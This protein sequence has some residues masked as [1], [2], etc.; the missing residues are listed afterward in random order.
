VF[1]RIEVHDGIVQHLQQR[2]RIFIPARYRRILPHRIAGSHQMAV[3]GIQFLCRGAGQ[4]G[5]FN[6]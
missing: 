2:L 3:N 4:F 6:I 1:V 5:I